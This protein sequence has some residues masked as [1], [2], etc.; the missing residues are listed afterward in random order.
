MAKTAVAAACAVMIHI[1]MGWAMLC[2]LGHQT[3]TLSLQCIDNCIHIF[4]SGA[5]VYIPVQ[6]ADI[7][8]VLALIT[9]MAAMVFVQV[10]QRPSVKLSHPP[11]CELNRP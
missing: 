2:T 9:T 1:E 11:I 7:Q 3:L 4:D 6:E 8:C 5:V 10:S